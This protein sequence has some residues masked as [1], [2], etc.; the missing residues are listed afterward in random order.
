MDK[1]DKLVFNKQVIKTDKYVI[2]KSYETPI[3]VPNN[4]G[5]TGVRGQAKNLTKSIYNSIKR[6]KDVIFG[7]A[8]ANA[9]GFMITLTF[10]GSKVDRY[11]LD[12][13]QKRIT[14]NLNDKKKKHQ[15]LKWLLVP[16]RHKDEAW[17]MHGLIV[18]LPEVELRDTGKVSKSGRKIY[19]W[20][21]FER[22]FG[23]NT[24]VDIRQAPLDEMYKIANYITK[25]ITKDLA[26]YR[27]NRKKYWSSKG[28]KK[29][30]K[31][32]TLCNGGMD[33][34]VRPSPIIADKEYYIKDRQTGEIRNTVNEIVTLNLPF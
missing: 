19:N 1:M 4:N 12:K 23:F 27:I 9:W 21:D 15:Q 5:Y 25:Y 34:L 10:D 6:T 8:I 14:Q 16:E 3:V 30:E 18:G 32:N 31:T 7:Y 29:P 22:K 26:L 24:L 17:H 20:V 33:D 13:I 2:R 11:D 28:L